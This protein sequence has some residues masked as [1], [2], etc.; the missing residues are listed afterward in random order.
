VNAELCFSVARQRS[1]ASKVRQLRAKPMMLVVAI[2][3]E[4]VLF[5]SCAGILTKDVLLSMHDVVEKLITQN[6]IVVE[7]SDE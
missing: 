2:L 3:Q 4:F 6:H 7:R 1:D 5:Q